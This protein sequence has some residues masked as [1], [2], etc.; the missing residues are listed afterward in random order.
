MNVEE[1]KRL[2]DEW[3]KKKAKNSANFKKQVI[4]VK[5]ATNTA[6]DKIKTAP[7][8]VKKEVSDNEYYK[9]FKKMG[10][11]ERYKRAKLK[12][13][14]FTDTKLLK[15]FRLL[16]K[17]V[18][19]GRGLIVCGDY[20]TGKTH[21]AFALAKE[22]MKTFADEEKENSKIPKFVDFED[23]LSDIRIKDSGETMKSYYSSSVLIIDD[24]FGQDIEDWELSKLT[25]V[26]GKRYYSQKTTII[27]AN[28]K[29][30]EII[31]KSGPKLWQRLKKVSHTIEFTDNR[32]KGCRERF[33]SVEWDK[34]D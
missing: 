12:D 27:T 21:F 14:T 19:M 1:L 26:I 32:F 23:F 29:P 22:I 3:L 2:N 30:A 10:I 24:L 17:A 15:Y 34:L 7:K 11:P 5:K 16:K 28:I 8:T 4:D 6:I 20:E 31:E 13:F 9:I 18:E 33:D 25:N